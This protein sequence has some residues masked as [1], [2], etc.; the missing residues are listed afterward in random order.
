MNLLIILLMF[1][2]FWLTRTT[3]LRNAVTVFLVQSAMVAAAC[4]VVGAET[5][6][7]HFFLAALLTLVIKAVLIP[8]ALYRI[9]GRLRREREE[10]SLLSPNYS[11]LAAA[12]AVVLAYGF[13]DR[14]LPGVISRDALAAAMSLIL[15]GLQIII[16]RH[17]AVLQIVGLST[18]ENGLYLV[19]LSV[20]KGLPLIIEFGILLDVLIAVVVLVILTYRLKISWLSTDT[21]L[22]QKLK[23]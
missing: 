8:Y 14:A 10:E 4:L 11:S 1:T 23:G 16:I 21:S 20:T 22:L 5:G 2:A 7:T 12:F 15:I 19:S 9:V 17:Q 3:D 6:E 13:I 18:L